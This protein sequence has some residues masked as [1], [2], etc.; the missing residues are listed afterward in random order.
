MLRWRL[1]SSAV[2]L[3]V[4]LLLAYLDYAHNFGLP[5]IWLL[6]LGFPIAVMAVS[7]VLELLAAKK[8][9]P[10][11]WTVNLGTLLTLGSVLVPIIRHEYPTEFVVESLGWSLTAFVIAVVLVLVGEMW[12]FREPGHAVVNVALSVFTIAYVGLLF[13]IYG[14]LRMSGGNEWGMVAMSSVV[15][16]VK[17]SDSGAYTVG[18]L[19]G[20]HKMTPRLS[21]KKTIEGAIGG[22]ACGCLTSWLFFAFLVPYLIG[23][24]DLP[25]IA[26]WRAVLYG[27]IVT[28]AGMIGDLAESLLKRDMEQKDSSGWLPGLGGVLDVLDSLLV[29]APAAY[30][31]WAFG[32]IGP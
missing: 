20:R 2:I 27:L 17:V 25:D 21:P 11:A 22:L 10:L 23:E 16:I 19:I 32:L 28:V 8:L 6:P 4:V 5:G 29:A 3:T 30:M 7:E 31:C 14:V 13:S 12:R 15:V 24:T 26:W 18:R 9:R 1:I